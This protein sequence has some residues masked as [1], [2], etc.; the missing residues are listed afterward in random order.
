MTKEQYL[1]MC[2]QTGQK[3]DWD[4]CPVEWEDFPQPV[5][6]AVSIYYLLGNKIYPEVGFTGKDYTNFNFLLERFNV[7]K[8]LTDF[9]FEILTFMESRQI[10][11]SQRKLKAEW[12]KIKKK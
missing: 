1:M 3:V 11:E 12:A 9:T 5:L 2:E 8:H 10:E 6:D 4:K 7:S